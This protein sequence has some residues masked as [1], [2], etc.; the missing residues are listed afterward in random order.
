MPARHRWLSHVLGWIS[1][2]RSCRPP[3]SRQR[4]TYA[5]F[6]PLRQICGSLSFRIK[7]KT[8]YGVRGIQSCCRTL[9]AN[10]CSAFCPLTIVT[11]VR[12]CKHQPAPY[13][14]RMSLHPVADCR[15]YQ[16]I[17][18]HCFLFHKSPPNIYFGRYFQHVSG[19]RRQSVSSELL[20]ICDQHD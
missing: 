11:S 2:G 15:S 12:G 10:L 9:A 14:Q 19:T 4:L 13:S 20:S 3:F 5:G 16:F 7:T 18:F 1:L 8:V 17:T 6:R